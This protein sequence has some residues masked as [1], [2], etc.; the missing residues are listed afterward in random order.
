V[1]EKYCWL[2]AANRMNT[3]A[4]YYMNMSIFLC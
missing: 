4:M 3:E 1:R 2:D